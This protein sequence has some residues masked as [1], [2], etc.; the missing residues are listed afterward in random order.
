MPQTPQE[1]K[2]ILPYD[3]ITKYLITETK[4]DAKILIKTSESDPKNDGDWGPEVLT[5]DTA[6]PANSNIYISIASCKKLN[7]PD[8]KYHDQ[9]RNQMECFSE[10]H[11]LMLDDLGDSTN[12][13]DKIKDYA[14]LPL[15]PTFVIETSPHNYQALYVLATPFGVGKRASDITKQLAK[16]AGSDKGAINAV[17]WMRLPYGIN[18]KAQHCKGKYKKGFPVTL[19]EAN[20]T[21]KY[22]IS[23]IMEAYNITL[24]ETKISEI[25]QTSKLQPQPL[26]GWARYESAVL[27]I[28]PDLDR[29]N[30][31][32]VAIALHAWGEQGRALFIEWSLESTLH[33]ASVDECNT[34]FDSVKY[35]SANPN[36]NESVI[37]WLWLQSYATTEH[38]WDYDRDY[39]IPESKKLIDRINAATSTAGIEEI[40]LDVHDAFLSGPDGASVTEATKTAYRILGES[41]TNSE[42]KNIVNSVK[43]ISHDDS[44]WKFPLD[45][46]G[47]LSRFHALYEN[48]Y[49][50]I[51]EFDKR[52]KWDG[53]Q[54]VND[55]T[56]QNIAIDTINQIIPLEL[57]GGCTLSEAELK[58]LKK[59]YNVCGQYSHINSLKQLIRN[60]VSLHKSIKEFNVAPNMLGLPTQVLDLDTKIVTNNIPEN[61][62]NKKVRFSYDET[63]TCPRWEQFIL[64]IMDGDKELARFL[65]ILTG[66]ALYGRNTEQLFVIFNGAGANGKSTFINTLEWIMKDYATT[67]SPA[68]LV[69]PAFN[70][71]S[72]NASP[73]LLDL[74]QKRLVTVNEWE[75]NTFLNESLVKSLTGGDEISARALYANNYLKYKPEYL[76]VLAAN[77][78]PRIGGVS[79]AVWRRL[80]IIPFN[81][82]FNAPD[83]VRDMHLSEHFRTKEGSGILK[84][85]V[86]GYTMWKNTGISDA[87]YLPEKLRLIKTQYLE[88]NDILLSFLTERCVRHEHGART[89]S[90]QLYQHYKTWCDENGHKPRANKGFSTAIIEKGHKRVR[91]GTVNGFDEIRLIPHDELMENQRVAQLEAKTITEQRIN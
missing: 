78:L 55:P 5:K 6:F 65:Q 61:F 49:Y 7:A 35:D 22:E 44:C 87:K 85:A 43:K 91:I 81:V 54:W 75:E 71:N 24:N 57:E 66:Y 34:I 70:K 30:W 26:E 60:D 20:P 89:T 90:A 83:K 33:K 74:Y 25:T 1:F 72:S 18:N 3:F 9:Y 41:I 58:A 28:S 13:S 50:Y 62:I 84:W 53:A 48:A 56:S 86:D 76:I 88:E 16:A 12:A 19:K 45:D 39:S 11:M 4:P 59:W 68:T 79:E 42:I 36:G 46:K 21:A 10:M 47:N 38:G 32:N 67:T 29:T 8:E 69:K 64:E 63:A 77:H 27:K 52:L 15:K 23:T 73:D 31:L 82:N 14:E 17:R 40:L 37:G 2:N 80:I 51:P